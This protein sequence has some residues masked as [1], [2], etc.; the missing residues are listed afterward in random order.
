MGSHNPVKILTVHAVSLV[1]FANFVSDLYDLLWQACSLFP[2]DMLFLK[3]C[4]PFWLEMR[5]WQVEPFDM[6]SLT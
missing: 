5:K 4:L 6:D 2:A 3:N 1:L